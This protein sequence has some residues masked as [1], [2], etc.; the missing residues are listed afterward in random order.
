VLSTIATTFATIYNYN[1]RVSGLAREPG[2]RE[3]KKAI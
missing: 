2:R 1:S 3:K